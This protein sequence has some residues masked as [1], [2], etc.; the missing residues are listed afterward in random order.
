MTKGL[1]QLLFLGLCLGLTKGN[2]NVE[3]NSMI[4]SVKLLV[5]QAVATGW[6]CWISKPDIR[7]DVGPSHTHVTPTPCAAPA[8]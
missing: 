5:R 3:P 4:S 8:I 6:R 2:H 7:P 1:D